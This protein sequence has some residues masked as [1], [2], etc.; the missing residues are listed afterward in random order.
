MALCIP[1]PLWWCTSRVYQDHLNL[2]S[3]HFLRSTY[4]QPGCQL[5]SFTGSC[6]LENI[7]ADYWLILFIISLTDLSGMSHVPAPCGGRFTRTFAMPPSCLPQLNP[8]LESLAQAPD[9]TVAVCFLLLLSL[10]LS[11]FDLCRLY[12]RPL[13]ISHELFRII[14]HPFCQNRIEYPQNLA[15]Y[16]NDRLHLL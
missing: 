5:S 9:S 2:E 14:V 13:D 6:P 16:H 12:L 11:D 4:P 10:Y 7:P 1:V 8:I 15:G 3:P